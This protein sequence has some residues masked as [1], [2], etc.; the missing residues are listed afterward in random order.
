MDKSIE[1]KITV[2]TSLKTGETMVG[3]YEGERSYYR[4]DWWT[5]DGFTTY[6]LE[7]D[8]T[9]NHFAKMEIIGGDSILIFDTS[10]G[11]AIS[12]YWTHTDSLVYETYE[13]I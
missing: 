12:G 9:S 8:S 6:D 13:F 3:N 2:E 1:P 11:S 5:Y 4:Y 10:S 7:E